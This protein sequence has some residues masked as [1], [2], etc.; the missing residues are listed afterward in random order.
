MLS[1][2]RKLVKILKVTGV[3]EFKGDQYDHGCSVRIQF[4]DTN[5]ILD[6]LDTHVRR[7]F[8]EKDSGKPTVDAKGQTGMS[9]PRGDIELTKRRMLNVETPIRFKKEFVGYTIV[10]H[11]GA[12]ET[13]DIKLSEVNITNI[14]ADP[15]DDGMCLYEA[16]AYMKPVAQVRG[17]IDHMSK[18][19]IEITLTP[20]SSQQPDLVDQA[21][22]AKRDGKTADAGKSE[23]ADKQKADAAAGD[24]P[25]EDPFAGTDL[26]RGKVKTDAK[27]TTKGSRKGGPQPDGSWPF[28]SSPAG[29]H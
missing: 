21:N 16:N 17:Y 13:S 24:A 20:P 23:D 6:E 22:K 14:S 29:A 26:A 7:A 19:E 12:T 18:S 9:L 11:R 15:Q 3:D 5:E 25:K 2:E 4:L 8:Y 27:V 1:I 10:F 28:P